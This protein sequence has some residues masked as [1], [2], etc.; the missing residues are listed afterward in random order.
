M[1]AYTLMYLSIGMLFF[2]WLLVTK[3]ER[4]DLRAIMKRSHIEGGHRW[5]LWALLVLIYA[6]FWPTAIPA[7]FLYGRAST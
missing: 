5:V 7:T 3:M 6:V 4:Y 1:L 2:A